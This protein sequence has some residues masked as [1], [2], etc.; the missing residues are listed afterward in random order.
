M[1]CKFLCENGID[2]L[3][4]FNEKRNQ[5]FN[6]FLFIRKQSFFLVLQLPSIDGYSTVRL[7]FKLKS[8][9]K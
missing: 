2:E 7:T 9:D 8:I 3:S 1:E 4:I 5:Q 6:I